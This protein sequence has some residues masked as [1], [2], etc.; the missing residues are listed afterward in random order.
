VDRRQFL[1]SAASALVLQARL[2]AAQ[3]SLPVKGKGSAD[4]KFA[5]L[6]GRFQEDPDL[7]TSSKRVE[8]RGFEPSKPGPERAGE[9]GPKSKR[10]ISEGAI[11]L[12]IAAE[13]TNKRTYDSLYSS[14]VW[15]GLM[16]GITIGIGYDIGWVSQSDLAQDWKDYVDNQTIEILIR[17]TGR[18]GSAAAELLDALKAIKIQWN[19]ASAQFYSETL[20]RCIGATESALPNTSVLTNDC[21]GSLV[22]IAYN[23]GAAFGESGDRYREMRAIHDYMSQKHFQTIP[24][25]IRRMKRLWLNDPKARGLILRR[26]AEALLFESGLQN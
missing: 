17:A 15:P 5:D 6:L 20:P 12:I 18:R 4:K 10:E 2:K 14:P 23:R 9:R 25:E 26:E 1:I 16:S 24:G 21:F 11:K 7:A 8:Q 22:S 13:I 19:T 3:S